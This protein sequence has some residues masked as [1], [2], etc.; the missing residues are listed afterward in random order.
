MG[1]CRATAV[2]E[3][4]QNSPSESALWTIEKLRAVSWVRMETRE[5]GEEKA[6]GDQGVS[7]S[8]AA[9]LF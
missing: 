2:D 3:K 4:A 9:A 7:L 1:D 5:K 8:G 6:I